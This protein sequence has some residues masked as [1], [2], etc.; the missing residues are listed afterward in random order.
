VSRLAKALLVLASP[1]VALVVSACSS[2]A[3]GAIGNDY[4]GGFGSAGTGG[5]CATPNT[6]CSCAE[7][8]KLIQCGEVSGM[9]AYGQVN[10]EFGYRR[11]GSGT[12]SSCGQLQQV[13]GQASLTGSLHALSPTHYPDGGC[14]G[15]L[16][17]PY[18]ISYP[19][20]GVP[21]GG[22][23]LPSTGSDGGSGS[24]GLAIISD[25]GVNVDAGIY[26]VMTPGHVAINPITV[27]TTLN[28]V[29]VYFLF[30]STNEMYSSFEQ[31][32]AQMPAVIT[33]V[34]SSIPNTAF[35]LGKFTNYNSWPY[36]D[37]AAANAVYTPVL[38]MTTDTSAVAGAFAAI[39][40]GDFA[41]KPYV[42]AQSSGVALYTMA[43]NQDLGSWVGFPNWYPGTPGAD[44][45][46]N[47]TEYF[48]R[49]P[50]A[51]WAGNFYQG[52]PCPTGT[53]G[54]PCFRP[55]AF[56]V[57]VLMQDSPVMNGPAGSFP[58]YQS[59]PRYF[60]VNSWADY[61][62]ENSWYWWDTMSPQEGGTAAT[63]QQ[64]ISIP[65]ATVGQ[66]QVWMGSAYNNASNYSITA[67]TAYDPSATMKCTYNGYDLGTG[68]DA[69]FDFTV[70]ATPT[71]QRYWFDT[72][73]SAY[74]TVLYIINK[75]TGLVMACA[76]DSFWWL[77]AL[78]IGIPGEEISQYN[79]AIVGNLP[80]GDYRL[81]LDSNPQQSQFPTDLNPDFYSGYQLNMWP[82]MTDPMV[83][84]PG[85]PT[86]H[87]AEASTPGY[88]QMLDALATPGINA[89]V[90]AIEMSGLTCGQTPTAW[91][92]NFTRWSL[93]GLAN[94]TGAVASGQ[95]IV[96]SVK[97]DGTPGPASGSDPRCPSA[98]NLGSV[99]T[100]A[101][102]GL[103]NNNA[104]PITAV[105]FDF[106]D[107]TDYDGP[108][109]GPL[110]LT[111][112]NVDDATFVQS[113]T[114]LPV[115][116]CTGPSGASYASC[117]PGATPNFQISFALPTSP[118]A[119]VQSSVDQ[120]FYFKI[121]LYGQDTLVPLS[122]TPVVI[123]VPAET[124][125]ST[126]NYYEDYGVSCPPGNTPQWGIFSWSGSTPSDSAVDFLAAF[127]SAP[128]S[129]PGGVDVAPEISPPF[130]TM[131]K[132]PPD[133][134]I[135]A[136]NLGAYA[137]TEKVP[138][139]YG[140]VRIHARLR[141]SSDGMNAPVLS[142]MHLQVDCVPS[143]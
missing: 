30:N 2:P 70:P 116:G 102:A 130:M 108:P 77:S 52:T 10:C 106:D 4:S 26:H 20:S 119:V 58:Y 111:P 98:A 16:C 43:L 55:S 127:G 76:D 54:A 122:A 133:T 100:T 63:P 22:V 109:G 105:P 74:D 93:E 48:G 114:A 125:A 80:P 11:C 40:L 141:A 110:L 14:A 8:G 68:P 38:A 32:S 65:T 101:I 128:G 88:Q 35:G 57:V 118:V 71:P 84:G 86:V 25:A 5:A 85:S 51:E 12:W 69:E 143:E 135:G 95:P 46:W 34:E 123:I 17:D 15:D 44:Y 113:I 42:V 79:S 62:T 134:D 139:N 124:L 41:N 59:M 92:N 115:P 64:V 18:C 142:G 96:L 112:Y 7:E 49:A 9:T 81:V 13:T 103:T 73:G 36:A 72:E 87:S 33:S 91:E 29:D 138:E 78:N 129:G 131:Q 24:V 132:G 117:A 28:P 61:T 140:Y 56:H 82:D 99:V 1:V 94:D 121:Y 27:T 39:N 60:P 21:D 104:Q 53:L 97:Q 19:G 67:T 45:W 126:F 107:D 3:P 83:S 6:G 50:Y 75:A 137:Q 66:A 89:K 136:F 37:Q 23:T 90:G 120:I 31:L 47:T